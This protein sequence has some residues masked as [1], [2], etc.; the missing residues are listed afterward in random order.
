M[1]G[2][3]G[4]CGSV[5]LIVVGAGVGVPC[6]SSWADW[7]WIQDAQGVTV[8]VNE[9]QGR[10]LVGTG[11]I[12]AREGAPEGRDGDTALEGPMHGSLN[13]GITPGLDGALEVGSQIPDDKARLEPVIQDLECAGGCAREELVVTSR[14]LS[15]GGGDATGCDIETDTSDVGY[16][17]GYPAGAHNVCTL[18]LFGRNVVGGDVEIARMTGGERGEV[19]LELTAAAP[20][21]GRLAEKVQERQ[22]DKHWDP[23]GLYIAFCGP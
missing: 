11:Y 16:H 13:G 2:G 19:R 7:G 20:L 6:S 5:G 17:E 4:V 12:V 22:L 14:N 10:E 15:D 1:R 9:R 21:E 18:V 3:E 8:S 23:I